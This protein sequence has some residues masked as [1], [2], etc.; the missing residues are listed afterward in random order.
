MY[1]IY[2]FFAHLY[3]NRALLKSVP[4]FDD[5][6]FDV[7]WLHPS[8]VPHRKLPLQVEVGIEREG[9]DGADGCYNRAIQKGQSFYGIQQN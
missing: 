3:R 4:K 9:G 7:E 5:F 2:H 6:P 8:I 1:S